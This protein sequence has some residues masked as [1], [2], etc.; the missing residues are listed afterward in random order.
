MLQ[1]GFQVAV[2]MWVNREALA[3]V[4]AP[5]TRRDGGDGGDGH[6][7]VSEKR[8]NVRIQKVAQDKYPGV[9]LEERAVAAGGAQELDAA[10][11]WAP[12]LIQ[13][14]L[15]GAFGACRDI[16]RR[17]EEI[18]DVVVELVFQEAALGVFFADGADGVKRMSAETRSRIYVP[19]AESERPSTVLVEGDLE[20]AEKACQ[21]LLRAVGER[22]RS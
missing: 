15:H 16:R 14:G 10:S 2:H 12:L 7:I 19:H 22:P 20:G 21:A 9:K 13:G 11:L 8:H 17:V 5:G 3:A 6:A 4:W 1:T 18:D